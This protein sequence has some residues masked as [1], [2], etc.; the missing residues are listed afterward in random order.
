MV[1]RMMGR[2]W[3]EGHR[4]TSERSGFSWW[5]DGDEAQ[6]GSEAAGTEQKCWKEDTMSL[7]GRKMRKRITDRMW[8]R[9]GRE[10]AAQIHQDW[11]ELA[12][13]QR[14]SSEPFCQ[15]CS[16]ALLNFEGHS[17]ILIKRSWSTARH[18][19]LKSCPTS[20]I[21]QGDCRSPDNR[22]QQAALAAPE[23]QA[24]VD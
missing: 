13:T 19:E 14:P 24:A 12:W 20:P 15:H 23:W 22:R 18:P 9:A 16:Q 3:D 5:P 2:T 7:E 4:L 6:K 8:P 11:V 1:G 21:P 10:P 17:V